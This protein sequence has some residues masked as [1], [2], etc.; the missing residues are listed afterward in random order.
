MEHT[1]AAFYVSQKGQ[2]LVRSRSVQPRTRLM[3]IVTPAKTETEGILKPEITRGYLTKTGY[4][5]SGEV[6]TGKFQSR[7]R[8]AGKT[9]KLPKGASEISKERLSNP[10][11]T[12]RTGQQRPRQVY[13]IFLV[14]R[15]GK[16]TATET[17]SETE[18]V[19]NKHTTTLNR[20][21]VI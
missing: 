14:K 17:G 8:T 15:Q 10:V 9:R 16:D 6:V 5:R 19:A 3:N 11:V 13:R 21:F 4:I 1:V 18:S 7:S 20:G 2:P 12:P